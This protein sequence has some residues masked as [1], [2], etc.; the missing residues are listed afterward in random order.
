MEFGIEYWKAIGFFMYVFASVAAAI[1]I[2]RNKE[3]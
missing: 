1:L 3:D 2:L